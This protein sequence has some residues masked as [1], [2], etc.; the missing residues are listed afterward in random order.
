MKMVV[1]ARRDLD[2]SAGKLAAQVAHGVVTV[3]D[4]VD[5][6]TASSWKAEGQPKIVVAV[7][8]EQALRELEDEARFLGLPTGLVS[9]A[10][11]TELPPGTAT[12]LAVGPGD[13]A[14]VDRVTGDLPLY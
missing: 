13:A 5:G 8:G 14:E 3:L 7:D 10:G 1:A 6:S 11:R 12:C 2:L 9:D 4:H